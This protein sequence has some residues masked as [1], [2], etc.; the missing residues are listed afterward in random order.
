MQKRSVKV[1]AKGDLLHGVSAIPVRSISQDIV[2][3]RLA[4]VADRFVK[5]REK[6][7]PTLGGQS[8]RSLNALSC[9][10]LGSCADVFEAN[11]DFARKKACTRTGAQ[12][13][14]PLTRHVKNLPTSQQDISRE[15]CR[16]SVRLCEHE[17][18]EFIVDSGASLHMMSKHEHTS[19]ETVSS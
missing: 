16:I 4:R 17:V 11:M 9:E 14:E 19:G 10:Q 18:R 7:G 2:K 6:K 3:F 12:S 8:G 13:K 1:N 15:S 5:E